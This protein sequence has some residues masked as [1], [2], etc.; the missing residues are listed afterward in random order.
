[1]KNEIDN[2][3]SFNSKDKVIVLNDI[4]CNNKQSKS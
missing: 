3:D 1:M 4:K 2:L